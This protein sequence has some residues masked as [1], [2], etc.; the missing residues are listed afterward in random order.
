MSFPTQPAFVA[1]TRGWTDDILVHPLIA[2]MHDYEQAFDAKEFDKIGAFFSA[3]HVYTKSTG[4]E[5]NGPAGPKQLIED[6]S[7]FTEHFHEP[8]YGVV[9]ETAKGYRFIGTAKLYVNL[10]QSEEKK[11]VDVHGRKW[12]AVSQGSFIFEVAKDSAGPRGFK[13]VY[14]QVFADPT[15]FLAI[16]LKRGLVP[17]E[18]LTA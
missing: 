11:L 14:T 7:L 18:S 4:Q 9:H 17:I 3:D 5:F 15:P 2:F 8:S 1:Y 16:A 13:F 10:P 12:E 6:Y